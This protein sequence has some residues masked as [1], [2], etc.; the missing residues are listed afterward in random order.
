[1][2][3]RYGNWIADDNRFN[4]E[5]PPDGFLTALFGFDPALVI[6]PSRFSKRYL[7]TRRRIN[8][9]G[10]GDVAML[11]NRHPDTNM[12]YAHGLLPISHLNFSGAWV[13]DTLFKQLRER[14]TW[15]ITGGPTSRLVNPGESLEKL[16]DFVEA[17]DASHEQQEQRGLRDKFHHMGR[18]AWRSMQARLG[19]RNKRA[20]NYHGVGKSL[21]P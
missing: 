7:L 9:A 2:E 18:D 3:N 16:A 10:L 19:A 17:K 21:Q 15:A 1:M 14:D 12:L 8:S 11:N 13:T 6:I 20:S 5:V 4:L